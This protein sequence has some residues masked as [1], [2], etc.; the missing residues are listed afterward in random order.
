MGQIGSPFSWERIAVAI[1]Q[2]KESQQ[3]LQGS[4]TANCEPILTRARF[5]DVESARSS[6]KKEWKKRKQAQKNL[7]GSWTASWECVFMTQN[8]SGHLEKKRDER[9]LRWSSCKKG[10]PTKASGK[11]NGKLWAHYN[12]SPFSWC[13]IGA[14][15]LKNIMKKK[16]ARKK[17]SGQLNSKLGARFHEA[18][19]QRLSRKK[20][21]ERALRWPSCKKR[22]LRAH[23]NESP[24]SWDRIGAVLLKK[25]KQEKTSGQ[26]NGKLGARF[27]DAEP[28][29][30]SKK[31]EKQRRGYSIQLHF[32]AHSH[33]SAS[34]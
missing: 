16:K 14:V 21:D 8:R 7:Q 26:S 17:S 25:R 23:F 1:L 3:K 19:S 31:N 2:K 13:G 22:K 11:S 6:W 24:F 34:N 12:E 15:I 4:R 5:H 27:H 18:E 10:K 28:Q 29:R 20:R 9:V 33:F 30:L 32:I